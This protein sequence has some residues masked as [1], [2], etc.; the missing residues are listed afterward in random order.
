MSQEKSI[1]E[2]VISAFTEQS[3]SLYGPLRKINSLL[4]E[5]L[6][7]TTEFQLDALKSYSRLG[8]SQLK[9]ATEVKDADSVRDYSASQAELFSTLSKKVLEDAKTLADLSIQFKSEVEKVLEESRAQAFSK[10]A[11]ETKAAAKPAAK[12]AGAAASK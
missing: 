10:A 1:Q 7:K 6:E 5:N 11:E 2:K 3:K 12:P 9:Q 4:V 8:L